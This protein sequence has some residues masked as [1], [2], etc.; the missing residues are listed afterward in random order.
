VLY[1]LGQLGTEL[2]GSVAARVSGLENARVPHVPLQENWS[3]YTKF[4]EAMST[5]AVLSAH[6]V[7]EG[8]VAVALAEMGFSM[9][10]GIEIDLPL[11]KEQIFAETP[12][13]LVVEVDPILE[14][15]FQR[16]FGA[17]AQRL[18]QTTDAH[19]QLIIND[20]L[21]ADLTSLKERWQHGL[22]PYY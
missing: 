10:A 18:G 11:S 1:L 3:R 6:D 5:N 4:Y 12:G 22:T 16:I 15:D 8:G 9:V 13:C 2:G 21:E 17:D 14:N 20:H 19:R 7:G